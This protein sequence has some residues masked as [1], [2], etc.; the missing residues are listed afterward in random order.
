[1]GKGDHVTGGEAP[2]A[3]RR[4]PHA[5]GRDQ[6]IRK[7]SGG[8]KELDGAGRFGGLNLVGLVAVVLGA[9]P[10]LTLLALVEQ[11]WPPLRELD[12]AVAQGL[13]DLIA[14]H[15]VAV[16]ALG[17]ASEAGGGATAGFI[18]ALAVLWLLIR[19]Q[20]RLAAYGAVTGIGLGVLVPISK[21]LIGRSRPEV[22][23]RV[24]ELPT[25]AS[26]P[27]GHAMA[28][29]VVWGA[30]ALVGLSALPPW[31]R[32]LLLKAAALLV[33]IVGFTRL[34]LGVHFVS[35]VLAGWAL[36]TAWL[37]VTTAAFRRWL[38][39][40]H[41]SIT[42]VGLGERPSLGMRIAP[43][44][45]AALPDGARSAARIALAGVGTLLL[46]IGLGLLVT[47]P[48][49]ETAVGRWDRQVVQTALT[50]RS[51]EL[52]EVVDA[53]SML[54][55][56]WAIVATTV[57]V[58]VLANAYRGSWRPVL[59]VLAAVAGEVLIYAVASEVISRA[60]PDVQDLTAGLP[61]A[62]SYP[63]GHVAATTA[64]YGALCV[65]LLSYFRGSW[66]WAVV[67]VVVLLIAATMASRIYLAAHYPTDT[68]AGLLLGLLWLSGLR[69]HLRV[70][71]A[72]APEM[73]KTRVGGAS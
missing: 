48:L 31:R 44:D 60:R 20:R 19:R 16:Q 37:A 9:L 71:R 67:G 59:F 69:H 27:S 17:I 11:R 54:G 23:L 25:N 6:A 32:R 1:M 34:A 30:L 4:S 36:G 43:R 50:L 61:A 8:A 72:E 63:S 38:R 70:T 47:G 58:A 66:Q 5:A 7:T 68:L 62:A 21:A 12:T 42:P 57:A 35:D 10:F 33:A 73:P 40:R 26:F 14:P 65:L 51:P 15:P 45:E 55:G 46:V 49:A 53:I 2:S 64:A 22:P 13:N 24:V 56:L 52:T 18:M 39:Y 28:S 41:D 3:P 29:V